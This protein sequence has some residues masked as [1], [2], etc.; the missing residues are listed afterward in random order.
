MFERFTTQARDVVKAAQEEA[1]ALG[2]GYI[3]TEHLLL[4]L[5]GPSRG[6]ASAVLTTA[7]LDHDRV[8]AEIRGL[9]GEPRLR[10]ADAEA[11]RSIGIDLEA[12]RAKLEQAFG[13]GALDAEPPPRPR[14]LFRRRP[15]GN[16]RLDR[17]TA[18]PQHIPFTPRSKKVLELS[19]REAIR[20][21]HKT[22]GAEHILLGLI[23]EGEGLAAKIM[24]NAGINLELLRR[25]TEEAF[26]EAA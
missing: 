14:G 5:L 1:R 17:G 26:K 8:R 19:L 15:A 13:P 10:D 2:H 12:I 22:I 6:G 4:A 11:L 20:L 7:G 25:R 18:P 3:G 9:L 21:N 23:R 16:R 24:V